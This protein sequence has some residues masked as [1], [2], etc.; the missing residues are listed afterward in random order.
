MIYNDTGFNPEYGEDAP[1][2]EQ[3]SNLTGVTILEFG[4]P[5]CV[6]CQSAEPAVRAV[7]TEHSKIRHVKVYDGKGKRLGREFRVKLW[8][9]LVL[10]REGKEV[11]RLVRP[12]LAD[13]VRQLVA[14]AE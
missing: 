3:V 2:L 11:A 1:T 7:L 9:T 12:L 6:H 5:W 10:L 14:H 8:P 4:A 13:E